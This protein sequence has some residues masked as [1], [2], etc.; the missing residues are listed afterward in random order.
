MPDFVAETRNVIYMAETKARNELADSVVLAKKRAAEEWCGHAS[1]F[2]KSIGKKPWRYLLI[3]HD[4]VQESIS[5]T[6][7]EQA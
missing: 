4:Q 1:E 7:F 3:P 6:A 5:L 2:N